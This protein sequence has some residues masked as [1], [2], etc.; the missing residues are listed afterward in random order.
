MSDLI[1]EAEGAA[2]GAESDAA[3]FLG[4]N[5]QHAYILILPAVWP[6]GLAAAA[7]TGA[8]V[9]YEDLEGSS[10]SSSISSMENQSPGVLNKRIEFMFNPMTYTIEKSANWNHQPTAGGWPT[11]TPN[12]VGSG[13]RSLSVELFLDKS[14]TTDGSVQGDVDMLFSTLQPTLSSLFR[15]PPSPPF[16]LFGWGENLGFLAYMES[17]RVEFQLFRP[18][19]TPTR[20]N[21]AITMK[22][23]PATPLG[24]NPTSGGSARRTR[25]LVAGDSLQSIS[26][27]EYGKP[28]M[29]RA[30]AE[31]NGIEDPTRVAPGTTVLVPSKADAADL[32]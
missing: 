26:F 20:A 21:C 27:R 10:N 14:Y 12:W 23:V 28:T 29:W 3:K 15:K 1:S 9:G 5:L 17:V 31:V 6:P 8:E 7:A 22:E 30:L 16:V 13:Q 11:A 19:G 25:Q 18:D 2:S 32:A 24:Q 4:G